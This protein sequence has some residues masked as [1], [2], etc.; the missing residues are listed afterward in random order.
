MQSTIENCRSNEKNFLDLVVQYCSLADPSCHWSFAIGL[1]NKIMSFWQDIYT[2]KLSV[3]M[4]I[5]KRHQDI[6]TFKKDKV[7]KLLED[8]YSKK[9]S[10]MTYMKGSISH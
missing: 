7:R 5:P 10:L 3:C 2:A 9:A 8:F 4:T 6:C 1:A